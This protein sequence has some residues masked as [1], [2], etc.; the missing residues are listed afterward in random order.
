MAIHN[1]CNGH[2]WARAAIHSQLVRRRPVGDALALLG[3]SNP[4]FLS[5]GMDMVRAI[6]DENTDKESGKFG[7]D[8]V[9]Q[10]LSFAVAD[11]WP[12]EETQERM[13]ALTDKVDD[14]VPC[15]PGEEAATGSIAHVTT[16]SSGKW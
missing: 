8:Q 4:M 15:A 1:G 9:L 11:G 10:E 5:A 13:W 3:R 2:A 14:I 12:R 6:L 7:I 16:S